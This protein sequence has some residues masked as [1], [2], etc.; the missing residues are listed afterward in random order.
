MKKEFYAVSILLVFLY[1]V[2][3][4]PVIC[5]SQDPIILTKINSNDA[6]D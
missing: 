1:G 3:L 4:A 6:S 2:S 5:E